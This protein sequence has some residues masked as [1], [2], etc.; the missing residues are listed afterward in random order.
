MLDAERVDSVTPERS[1]LPVDPE[2]ALA[3]SPQSAPEIAREIHA[4]VAIIFMFVPPAFLWPGAS[5]I[6]H[7]AIESPIYSRRRMAIGPALMYRGLPPNY[8]APLDDLIDLPRFNALETEILRGLAK[9]EW[10]L[11]QIGNGHGKSER[12]DLYEELR[13]L[14]KRPKT[15]PVRQA[16]DDLGYLAKRRFVALK[17][18]CLTL[19]MS[20]TVRQTPHFGEWKPHDPFG[21]QGVTDTPYTKYF[22]ELLR[23]V[24]ELPIFEARSRVNFFIS[25]PNAGG[26]IHRDYHRDFPGPPQ[27]PHFV[28]LQMEKK[29]FFL[30]DP[31][32]SEKRYIDSHAVW[33]NS[34]QHHGTDPVDYFTWS[35]RIDGKFT[36][37]VAKRAG[38]P[39]ALAT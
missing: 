31:E 11:G 34:N 17:T 12:R 13:Q 4:I 10:G 5:P 14:S 36:D 25:P 37:E 39:P 16:T 3:R 27:L 26:E 18:R 38:V 29:P 30:F 24:D 20:V 32:K 9:S 19:G 8:Y 23:F 22:P 7:V 2:Q 6:D 33:F 28:W 15:D 1:V 21:L 35:V